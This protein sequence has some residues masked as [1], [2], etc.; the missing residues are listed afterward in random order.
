MVEIILN[1]I[2]EVLKDI[3]VELR[4]QTQVGKSFEQKLNE[5]YIYQL[6]R[7]KK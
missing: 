5:Y 4:K 1:Q 3:L 6:N 7:S 2:L